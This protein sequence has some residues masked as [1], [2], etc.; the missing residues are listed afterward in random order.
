MVQEK[1]KYFYKMVKQKM[2]PVCKHYNQ[3]YHGVLNFLMLMWKLNI[4]NEMPR[5]DQDENAI[6]KN[7][8]LNN[9]NEKMIDP[10]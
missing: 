8:K 3:K 6:N 1:R 4:V 2:L 9:S 10:H 7:K 5:H